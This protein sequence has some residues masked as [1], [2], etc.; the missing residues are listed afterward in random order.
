[1]VNEDEDGLV[2]CIAIAYCELA[3]P[4]GVGLPVSIVQR[5]SV[6]DGFG[7]AVAVDGSAELEYENAANPIRKLRSSSVNI[8]MTYQ[9]DYSSKCQQHRRQRDRKGKLGDV[10]SCLHAE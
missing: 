9:H 5:P 6:L 8:G 7:L 1:M 4:V 10:S 2:V 3:P